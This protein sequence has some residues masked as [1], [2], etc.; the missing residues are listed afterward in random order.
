MIFFA[1]V[2]VVF[3]FAV[4]GG[5]TGK[6]FLTRVYDTAIGCT[7]ALVGSLLVLPRRRK[8]GRRRSRNFLEK[9]PRLF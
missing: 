7:L 8:P 4:V 6:L 9:L 1:S 3:V 5:W 2:Y